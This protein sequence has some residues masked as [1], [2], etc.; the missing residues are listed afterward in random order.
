VHLIWAQFGLDMGWRQ[1]PVD[2]QLS[3]SEPEDTCEGCGLARK[4]ATAYFCHA[5]ARPYD[6]LRCYLDGE[7]AFDSVHM[8]RISDDN[9]PL[10]VAEEKKR[11]ART[12]SRKA[13]F[14]EEVAAENTEPVAEAGAAPEPPPAAPPAPLAPP[15]PKHKA[16]PKAED[17]TENDG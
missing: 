14:E 1:T 3:Q 9:W 5:C 7:L 8:Q 6:P 13:M 2:W 15:A 11:R 10:V 17:W 12:M 16:K 4:R